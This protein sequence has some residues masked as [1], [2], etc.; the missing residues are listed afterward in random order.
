MII[1]CAPQAFGISKNRVQQDEKFT[2][3]HSLKDNRDSEGLSEFFMDPDPQIRELAFE[4]M[5]SVQDTLSIDAIFYGLSDL[6]PDVRSAAGF[7]I[8]QTIRLMT[9]PDPVLELKLIRAIASE[10]DPM[11]AKELFI[12]LGTAYKNPQTDFLSNYQTTNPIILEG[13]SWGIYRAGLNGYF[14]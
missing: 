14:N 8:G 7:S 4:A 1:S 10:T 9:N 3:I 13:I 12:S 2:S 5:G 6:N 11:V